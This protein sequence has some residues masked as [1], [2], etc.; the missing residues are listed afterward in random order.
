[1]THRVVRRSAVLV[2]AALVTLAGVA[3]ADVTMK[4]H[5]AVEGQGI[6][7]MANMSGT[8]TTSISGK[9]ARTDNDLQMESRLVRMFA[10]GVGSNSEIVLL[11]Q[12]KVYE[13]NNAK[14][15]YTESS[16]TE[17][18]AQ[19]EKA[20]EQAQQQQA[21]QPAP[22]GMDESECEWTDPTAEVSRTGQ[23]ATIAGFAAEQVTLV[24]KQSCKNRKTGAV[25]DVALY[26]DEWVAPSFDAG[27]E[28][29]AYGVAYAQQMGLMT[30]GREVTERAEALFGRYKSAWSKVLEK[31]QD[32]KGY[33]VKTTFSLGF[34]GPQCQTAGAQQ[35]ADSGGDSSSSAPTSTSPTSIAGQ[36]AGS[37]FKR[38][39]KA[40][41]APA[42][43][44]PA[45]PLPAAMSGL[46]VPLKVTSELLSV[47]KEPLAADAFAPPPGFKKVA[48]KD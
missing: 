36:I 42:P 20:M 17:R 8:T 45:T 35:T 47:S 32:I 4:E 34:G 26:L 46:I 33:P 31:M 16:L 37:L 40:E 19:M 5:L 15:T 41:E 3:H 13:L 21:K 30:G 9:R 18:R 23:K 48:E 43:A 2:P 14:R 6:M 28:A 24:T 44:T 29:R 38:K 25:C 7:A 1:M 11:D 39:K 12:D 10:H 22:T 27:E